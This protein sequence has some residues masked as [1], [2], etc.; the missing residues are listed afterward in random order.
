[1]GKNTLTVPLL[2]NGKPSSSKA[3]NTKSVTITVE[4]ADED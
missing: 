2:P 1:M 3:A 4:P